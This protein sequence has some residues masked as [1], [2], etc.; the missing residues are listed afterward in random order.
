MA[1]RP[2]SCTGIDLL[3][4]DTFNTLQPIFFPG[5]AFSWMS[6]I[7]HRLFL[8]KLLSAENRE[9][10]SIFVCRMACTELHL[11]G[12][13]AF[14]RLL[15]SLF[16]F[17]A[18]FLKT[19]TLHNAVGTL[20]RGSLSLLL[21]L[22]HDFPE[23]LSENFFSLSDAIPPRCV[24]FRNVIL[25][26]YP[27]QLSIPDPYPRDL[28]LESLPEMG[29]IP[30]VPND[31]ATTLPEELRAS[32]EGY[33]ANRLALEAV[34]LAVKQ[35]MFLPNVNVDDTSID[36][37]NVHMMN[38]ILYFVGVSS[39]AQAKARTGS[40]LFVATD[41]GV[42][43]FLRLASDL[44]AEGMFFAGLFIIPTYRSL[45][46]QHHLIG[47]LGIHLRY[48]NAHTHW[49]SSVVLYLFREISTGKFQEIT[50]KVLFERF[51]VHRPHPWGL[52]VTFIELLR[53]PRYD[54]WNKEF[55]TAAPE[56]TDL[57]KHVSFGGLF[58]CPT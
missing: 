44:D 46:G 22:L 58:Q 1:A 35:A 30:P 43:L 40:S 38:T 24:Q 28:K 13:S 16:K 20:Y 33:L 57:L 51:L 23:F 39:V 50:T 34:I 14:H 29:P 26:A 2:Q 17:M 3:P 19:A 49:F 54:F 47:S 36:R 52:I 37:Y 41:P 53:N 25:S 7:S 10:S 31:L 32:L 45:S 8:P 21:V 55:L 15:H 6:L 4:S 56:I 5:F 11:Q 48:P 9:V 27:P 42:A 18:P 12:W